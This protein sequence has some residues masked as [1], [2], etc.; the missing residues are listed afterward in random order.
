MDGVV[1]V[2]AVGSFFLA[3][4]IHPIAARWVWAK[5]GFVT[6]NITTCSGIWGSNGFIDFAGGV[7]VHLVGGIA[8][9]VCAVFVGPQQQKHNGNNNETLASLGTFILW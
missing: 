8:A 5:Q 6:T 9:I 2:V 4:F 1:V 3:G 7:V